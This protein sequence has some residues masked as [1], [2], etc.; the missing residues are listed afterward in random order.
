MKDCLHG[1]EGQNLLIC[2]QIFMGPPEKQVI[3]E[4][5]SLEVWEEVLGLQQKKEKFFSISTVSCYFTVLKNIL[6]N[7]CEFSRNN[8]M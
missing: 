3:D 8:T 4:K 6:L 7:A 5:R 1:L 2:N